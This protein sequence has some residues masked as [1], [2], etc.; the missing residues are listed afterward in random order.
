MSE[1]RLPMAAEGLQ[2]NFCKTL[3][4]DNFGLSDANL[5]ILQH[6][7]PKRPA[8]YAASVARFPPYLT[9][10]KFSMSLNG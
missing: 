5:Y 9:T 3:A 10:K 8:W 2:L 4:C 6:S 7:N 1:G